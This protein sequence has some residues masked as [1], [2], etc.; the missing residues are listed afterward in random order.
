MRGGDIPSAGKKNLEVLILLSGIKKSERLRYIYQLGRMQKN[1]GMYSE[2]I[3]RVFDRLKALNLKIV[4]VEEDF[5]TIYDDLKSIMEE[6]I[7]DEDSI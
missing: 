7:N 4:D 6:S 5:K 3:S 2:K 1:R